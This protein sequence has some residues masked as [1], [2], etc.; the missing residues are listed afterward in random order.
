MLLLVVGVCSVLAAVRPVPAQQ[1]WLLDTTV[2][3]DIV[4]NPPY[5]G[6]HSHLNLVFKPDVPTNWKT[7]HNYYE[8]IIFTRWEIIEKPT[9][10]IATYQLCFNRAPNLGEWH[11]C[12]GCTEYVIDENEDSGFRH[13]LGFRKPGV[14]YRNEMPKAIWAYKVADYNNFSGGYPQLVLKAKPDGSCDCPVTTAG[15]AQFHCWDGYPDMTQHYPI[16]VH[17]SAIVVAKDVGF[18]EP[19]WWY[20]E[21]DVS[22]KGGAATPSKIQKGAGLGVRLLEGNSVEVSWEGLKAVS[23]ELV[24]PDGRRAGKISAV[25]GARR[26]C[27]HNVARGLY[28]IRLGA[29]S[30]IVQQRALVLR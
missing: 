21:E 30:G 20:G 25:D 13:V 28:I 2:V 23:A 24:R 16:K 17:V 7:P 6:W 1:F 3:H 5:N 4:A 18:D 10:R 19:A 14:F 12:L 15:L 9:E 8:G 27:F 22:A 26:V 29:D 11:T